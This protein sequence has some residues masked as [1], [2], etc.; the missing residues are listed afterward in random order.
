M[1][2][3]SWWPDAEDQEDDERNTSSSSAS[4]ATHKSRYAKGPASHGHINLSTRTIH[5]LGLETPGKFLAYALTPL[6]DAPPVMMLTRQYPALKTWQREGQ[7]ITLIRHGKTE[8]RYGVGLEMMPPLDRMNQPRPDGN[9]PCTDARRPAYGGHISQLIINVQ[10]QLVVHGLTS[11][12]HRLD[13]RS[14]ILFMHDTMGVMEEVN[15]KIFPD[16]ET[17][18]NYM[19]GIFSRTVTTSSSGFTIG[20]DGL[21][22]MALALVPRHFELGATATDTSSLEESASAHYLLRTLCR[23]PEIA[24]VGFRYFDL[25]IMKL[26]KLAVRAVIDPLS[27]MFDCANGQLL[28]NQGILTLMNVLVTEISQILTG[29]PELRHLPITRQRFDRYQLGRLTRSIIIHNPSFTSFTARCVRQ[30]KDT[31]IKFVNGYFIRRGRQQNLLCP[32]NYTMMNSVFAKLH[33][34]RQLLGLAVPFDGC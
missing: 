3:G 16:I 29:L 19:L 32:I 6:P 27:T 24:A 20:M 34:N 1:S 7:G 30:G 11:I 4:K 21:G 28:P 12:K 8:T 17:R 2:D 26:R 31:D 18:P 22:T 5:I 14:T 13:R 25:L 33:L 10:S 23:S 15:L 9:K